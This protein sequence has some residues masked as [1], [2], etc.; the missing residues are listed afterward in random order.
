MSGI[1]TSISIK[2]KFEGEWLC[3]LHRHPLGRNT[4]MAKEEIYFACFSVDFIKYNEKELLDDLP[5]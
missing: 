3:N 4:E 5:Q 1:T 2:N